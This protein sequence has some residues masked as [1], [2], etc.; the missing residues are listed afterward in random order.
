[1]KIITTTKTTLKRSMKKIKIND[2][3]LKKKIQKIMI[4]NM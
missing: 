3:K 1:M 4:Q 2:L